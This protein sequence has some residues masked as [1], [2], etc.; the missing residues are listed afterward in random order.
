MIILFILLCNSENGTLRF[1]PKTLFYHQK[2][3]F[4]VFREVI[5]LSRSVQRVR[6]PLKKPLFFDFVLK[7]FFISVV[8]FLNSEGMSV[9]L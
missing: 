1:L 2:V 8:L 5:L 9:P 7:F 6:G 4:V 3:D